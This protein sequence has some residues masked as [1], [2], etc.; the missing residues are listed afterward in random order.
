VTELLSVAAPAHQRCDSRQWMSHTPRMA[1]I[2]SR[3]VDGLLFLFQRLDL[4][5]VREGLFGQP[6]EI[7]PAG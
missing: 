4:L 2:G 1:T 3:V 7:G 5:V 6:D